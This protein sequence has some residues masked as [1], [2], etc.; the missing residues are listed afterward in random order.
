MPRKARYSLPVML[1]D[2]AEGYAL[3]NTSGELIDHNAAFARFAGLRKEDSAGIDFQSPFSDEGPVRVPQL[4][5][6]GE[7]IQQIISIQA[8]S[9]QHLLRLDAWPI[10]DDE[11]QIAAALGRLQPA[12]EPE[13]QLTDQPELCWGLKLADELARRRNLESYPG[14]ASIIGLG[15]AHDKQMRQ[16]QAAIRARC[17]L[18]ICGERGTGRHHLARVIH[19]GW[20]KGQP[21]RA[22]LVPLDPHSLP[23][24]IL[25]RDF[26]GVGQG[27]SHHAWN[28]PQGSTILIEDLA[29]IDPVLQRAI[30]EAPGTVQVIGLSRHPAERVDLLPEFRAVVDLI[31][32]EL[33]PLRLRGSELPLLAQSLLERVREGAEKRVDGFSPAAL[34]QL[35]MH[36]WPGNWRELER[37]IRQ[38]FDHATGPLITVADLPA[39]IQ[40]AVGGA[41]MQK[42]E[43][44]KLA[45]AAVLEDSLIQA[46]RQAVESAL[47]QHGPNKAAVARALGIS[48]PKL[49]RLLEELGLSGQSDD[50]HSQ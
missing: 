41:W 50:D 22:G 29:A 31:T 32:L 19:G 48:R 42:P 37:T 5:F 6:S 30:A 4:V 8:D 18:V 3:W 44:A 17:N 15:P 24:E 38:A 21:R 16:V 26:L 7:V 45:Q 23:A 28:V 9:I 47:R 25:A 14:L 12:S 49:Y 27:G 13:A 35:R 33:M 11:G 39:A 2:A 34:E 1:M 43:E 20:Q 36:D 40:G 10:T 46:R